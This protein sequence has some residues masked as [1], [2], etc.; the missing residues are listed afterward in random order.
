MFQSFRALINPEK[1]WGPLLEQ[2]RKKLR[3]YHAG[4]QGVLV[5]IID[6]VINRSLSSQTLA[7]SK[8]SELEH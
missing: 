4:R 3:Y 5:A 2:N 7:R 8:V 6:R 1:K